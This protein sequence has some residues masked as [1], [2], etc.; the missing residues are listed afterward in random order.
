MVKEVFSSTQSLESYWG[1][2]NSTFEKPY[3]A[4]KEFEVHVQKVRETVCT[5]QTS[6]L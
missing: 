6:L 3:S 2:S 1:N 5:S 4:L